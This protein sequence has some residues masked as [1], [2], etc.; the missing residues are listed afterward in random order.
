MG[1]RSGLEHSGLGVFQ[2]EQGMLGR[3]SACITREGA[4]SADYP[5]ARDED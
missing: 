2:L 4:V 1:M 5:V 3:K